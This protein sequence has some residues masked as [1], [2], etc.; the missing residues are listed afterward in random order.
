MDNFQVS[1]QVAVYSDA[2]RDS[3]HVAM[4]DEAVGLFLLI[5]SLTP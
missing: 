1:E 2:D 3:M 4:A 5:F